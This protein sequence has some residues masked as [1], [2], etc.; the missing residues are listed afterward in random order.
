MRVGLW[1]AVV[2]GFIVVLKSLLVVGIQVLTAFLV[3]LAQTHQ[4]FPV[5]LL[6]GL[7]EAPDGLSEVLLGSV[8]VA[9]TFSQLHECTLVLHGGSQ[10]IVEE[11]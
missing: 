2:A 1:D 5:F 10:S 8:T 6:S 3:N 9:V 11:S 7:L 4:G